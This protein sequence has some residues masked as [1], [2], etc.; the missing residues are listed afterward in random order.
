MRNIFT[1]LLFSSLILNCQSQNTEFPVNFENQTEVFVNFGEGIGS[2]IVNPKKEGINTSNYVGKI[3]KAHSQVWTG[4][5]LEFTSTFDFTANN[6]IRLKVFSPRANVPLLL[7]LQNDD[8]ESVSVSRLLRTTVANEWEELVFDFTG[9]ASATYSQIAFMFD[10]GTMGDGSAD[11]TF[12]IDDISL[13]N[14]V[15]TPKAQID[16]PITFEGNTT[17]FTIRDFSG[18]SSYLVSDPKNQNNS[19]VKTTKSSS[20]ATW[21]GTT[22][23]TNL[24]FANA[25]PFS[26]SDNIISVKVYSPVAGIPIRL[27]AED[28]LNDSKSVEVQVKNT[29]VNQWETLVFDFNVPVEA[30]PA[31]N[32]ANT[33][34]KLSIFFDYG[35]V[36]TDLTYYWDEIYFGLATEIKEYLF[37]DVQVFPNPTSDFIN[38]RGATIT[39]AE[40]FSLSGQ[41]LKTISV[42]DRDNTQIDVT[43]LQTGIYLL[44]LT[45]ENSRKSYKIIKN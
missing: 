38:V 26:Q 16:L 28:H 15:L 29:L 37:A 12:L 1:I 43:D 19:V 22:M 9:T 17:D 11:F 35:K 32:L 24:G 3:I 18:N 8:D 5:K 2:V 14:N 36:G 21:A 33:Y 27:K 25:I 41:K 34:D 45:S 44:M 4:S 40:I 10:Y 42:L 30:T 7:K 31:L 20:S 13:E 6:S 23:C 39:G